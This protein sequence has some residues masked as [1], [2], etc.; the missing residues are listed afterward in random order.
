MAAAPPRALRRLAV[1][2]LALAVVPAAAFVVLQGRVQSESERRL[3]EIR[4]D[5]LD[6]LLF[7]VNQNAWDV[8][9]SWADRLARV[10]LGPA[11]TLARAEAARA[12]LEAT[13]AVRFV[14]AADPA[15]GRVSTFGMPSPLEIRAAGRA[16]CC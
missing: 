9:A 8:A 1:A 15:A 7:S 5:Q 14:L 11:D 12:F 10:P 16:V 4:D 2:L 3:A 6:G 13:P